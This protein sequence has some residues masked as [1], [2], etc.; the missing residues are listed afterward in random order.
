[1]TA[2]RGID[3]REQ[4]AEMA[5]VFLATGTRTEAELDSALER[6]RPAFSDLVDDDFE[7]VKRILTER[8]RID[9]DM[10]IAITSLTYEPWLDRRFSDIEWK[11][12]RVYKQ[13]L[14]RQRW[15]PNV[16]DTMDQL[17]HR[18]LDFAGDPDSPGTWARRGLAIGEVQSGKTATYLA[19]FNKAVD[20][21]YRL[22]IVLAGGTEVLR[23]QTQERVDEGLIGRDSRVRQGLTKGGITPNRHI[24]IG[25]LD[26]GLADA[27]GMTTVSQDFR[28]NSYEATNIQISP[29]SPSAYVFV[30]KKNKS[31]LDRL[32][33]WLDDQP[34]VHGKI[35][36]P[37]LLLDDES[38]YA[39]VNTKAETDPT[40]INLGIRTLLQGFSRS[41]Y[42][43][44]TA[45]PFANIFIDHDQADDLFPRDYVYALDAPT[46]YFG[47]KA[48]FGTIN[49]TDDSYV[50]G[51]DDAA[52]W[53]ALGHKSS[54]IVDSLP[55]SLLEAIE[56]FFVANAIRDLRGDNG[57]SA[58]LVNVSRFKAVQKQVYEL[59]T[60]EART[61]RNALDLH[62]AVY[63]SGSPNKTIDRLKAAFERR[64]TGVEF[65]WDEV[66]A[67]LPNATAR[68]AVQLHNSDRDLVM[69]T[70]EQVWEAPPRLIAIGG[71]VLSRG[72]TLGGLMVSYFHR[73]V[74]AYDTL[75][76][77][78]RWFGY[79]DGYVDL[80]RV[81]IDSSV[82]AQYRFIQDAIDELKSDLQDMH[83][84]KLTPKEFGLA[85]KKHPGALLVT[86]R[87]KMKATADSP[88]EISLAGRRI[89]STRLSSDPVIIEGNLEAFSLL[90]GH[91]GELD[92][93]GKSRHQNHW[94]DV[95][96]EHVAEFL[97]RF[98]AGDNEAI[99][100]PG[101]LSRFVRSTGA[102]RL[103]TWD[104]VI[105]SG[106]QSKPPSEVDGVPSITYFAPERTIALDPGE[107]RI[108]GKS[109]RLGS[110]EDIVR[111][112]NPQD[113]TLVKHAYQERLGADASKSGPGEIAYYPYL[114]RPALLLYPLQPSDSSATAAEGR[115][116][117]QMLHGRPLVAVKVAIPS[118][119][120][121]D[122][123]ADAVYVI[124]KVAQQKWF[125]EYRDEDDDNDVD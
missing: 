97:D 93:S 55:E 40:A 125:P 42:L 95:P 43:A 106:A 20:A 121:N 70:Q 88:K 60:V 25:E 18:L 124:N 32:T 44:V 3:P 33:Q 91:L 114:P 103:Q 84:Q 77:M 14:L 73:R 67:A 34:K 51:V 113:V 45:T 98:T 79:R 96:K 105:V 78:G 107:F 80:C 110:V 62:A 122:A 86:A 85:V 53:L 49:E 63:A 56:T 48:A 24:G 108:A 101:A 10:G 11:H 109:S 81:W 37:V 27:T 6:L 46:N 13:L 115:S 38:D 22:I 120:V 41:S 30:V 15:S 59:V 31:V 118:S 65:T 112:V 72:L 36:L 52:D 111:L 2:Y 4:L 26:A 71:D 104:V 100:L 8:L 35:E 17:T 12:W 1:M 47:S 28:K 76:Q 89:E 102:E 99:F 57:S 123:S 58:M 117:A 94:T 92:R 83:R 7:V 87:N 19:L 82:V 68:I 21:G 9:M 29:N 66:L 54:T 16:L 90:A 74:G 64:Y 116:A 75:M 61:L 119:G 39:S 50:E 23:Q 5:T 69:A